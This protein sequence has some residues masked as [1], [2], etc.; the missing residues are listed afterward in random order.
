MLC[1]APKSFPSEPGTVNSLSGRREYKLQSRI[2]QAKYLSDNLYCRMRAHIIRVLRECEGNT[3]WAAE[4][5][6]CSRYTIRKYSN[7][8]PF[9]H[10]MRKPSLADR[11][12]WRSLT[13]RQWLKLLLR[14]PQFS[15]RLPKNILHLHDIVRII[16]QHPTAARHFDL[17]QL[18][19]NPSAFVELLKYRPEFDVLCSNWS[20]F[21]W[22]DLGEL[23][24]YQPKYF[25]RTPKIDTLCPFF[26]HEIVTRNQALYHR[27]EVLDKMELRPPREWPFSFK[28]YYLRSHPE[29]EAEFHEWNQI[30]VA[31]REDIKHDQPEL[32]ARHFQT[33]QR[34][35]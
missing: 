4:I 24:Q 7:F 16:I 2:A 28:V 29:F 25:D 17:S 27:S 23:L 30:D 6:G 21:Q 20:I 3:E 35:D 12:D 22:H 10:L 18:N 15:P 33:L 31:D 19:T 14:H 26:W 5:L 1:S 32:Y 8:V 11:F 9:E 13:R 34:G